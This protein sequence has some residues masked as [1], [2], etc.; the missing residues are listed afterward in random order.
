[1]VPSPSPSPSCENVLPGAVRVDFPSSAEREHKAS[2]GAEQNARDTLPGAVQVDSPSS[3]QEHKSQTSVEQHARDTLPGVVQVDSPSAQEQKSQSS[4]EKQPMV[5]AEYHPS[6]AASGVAAV[7][8]AEAEA[9]KAEA[10]PSREPLIHPDAS[11]PPVASPPSQSPAATLPGFVTTAREETQ[12]HAD[13]VNPSVGEALG[14]KSPDPESKAT[15][16]A[17]GD[18]AGTTHLSREFMLKVAKRFQPLIWLD[19]HETYLP[20]DVYM[21]L[22]GAKLCYDPEGKENPASYIDLITGPKDENLT[23]AGLYALL[24]AHRSGAGK[25]DARLKG[26]TAAN[27]DPKRFHLQVASDEAKKGVGDWKS[28]NRVPF[29]ARVRAYPDRLEVTYI[30]VFSFNAAHKVCCSFVGAHSVDLE[31][32]TVRTSLAGDRLDWIYFGAHGSADGVWRRADE[33]EVLPAPAEDAEATAAGM[34]T[35]PVVYCTA[36]SHA[37]YPTPGTWCRICG[38]ANDHTSGPAKSGDGK[39]NAW[40]PSATSTSPVLVYNTT[41][42]KFLSAGG[43]D[44]LGFLRYKGTMAEDGVDAMHDQPWFAGENTYTNNTCR[45]CLWPCRYLECNNECCY[46]WC[47]SQVDFSKLKNRDEPPTRGQPMTR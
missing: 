34:R 31:H 29:Y 42:S 24:D 4:V 7:Q 46:N 22:Q 8:A 12:V 2:G 13:H 45:R 28:L 35:R 30:L 10:S 40:D 14:L 26:V 33:I 21:Y 1:M 27:L 36:G 11:P 3:V 25:D 23:E 19:E 6:E 47:E 16:A 32:V 39:F 20:A 15:E 41:D 44:G 17:P 9:K 37:M 38:L 18:D 5:Q 43:S